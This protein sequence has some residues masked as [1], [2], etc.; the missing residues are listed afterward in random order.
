MLK[1]WIIVDVL[2]RNEQI[3]ERIMKFLIFDLK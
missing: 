3:E 2:S 1:I